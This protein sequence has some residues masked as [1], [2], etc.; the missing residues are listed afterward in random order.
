MDNRKKSEYR[1]KWAVRAA[2]LVSAIGFIWFGADRGEVGVV[3]NKAINICFECIGI[4]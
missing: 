3:L 4:G 2:M 1:K